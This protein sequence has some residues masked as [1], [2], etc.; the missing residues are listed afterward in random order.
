LCPEKS[1]LA[2]KADIDKGHIDYYSIAL[3][4]RIPEQYVPSLFAKHYL[5]TIGKIIG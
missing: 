5:D 3:Q 4:L 1:R 2:Y